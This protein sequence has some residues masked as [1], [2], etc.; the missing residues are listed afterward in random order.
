VS[1]DQARLSLIGGGSVLGVPVGSR[2]EARVPRSRVAVEAPPPDVQASTSDGEASTPAPTS[3]PVAPPTKPRPGERPTG[4]P[5]T[6]PQV[7]WEEDQPLLAEAQ[8]LQPEERRADWSGRVFIDGFV[9]DD[10]RADQ[11]FTFGRAGLDLFG[12]NPFGRGGEFQFSGEGAFQNSEFGGQPDEEDSQARLERLAYHWGGNRGDDLGFGVGR[13][14]QRAFPEF[15]LLDGGE[16]RWRLSEQ[17]SLSASIGLLPE[18]TDDLETGDDFQV[19][20]GFEWVSDESARNSVRLG[21]QK[22]WHMGT[23]DRDL[24]VLAVRFQPTQRTTFSGSAW[25]DLYGSEDDLKDSST[26]LTFATVNVDQR[27]GEASNLGLYYF[28]NRLPQTLRNEL[29]DLPPE[30]IEETRIERLGVRGS[31]PLTDDLRLHARLDS[32]SDEEDSGSGGEVR[33][34]WRDAFWDDGLLSAALFDN[35][36][37]TSAGTGVRL[38]ATKPFGAQ[39][40]SLS[41]NATRFEQEEFTGTQD[42]LLQH[43]VRL[44]WDFAWNSRWSGSV[45]G[46]ARFGDEQDATTLGLYLQRRF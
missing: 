2:G 38:R 37:A 29:G 19:A 8:A 26:E 27:L 14:L 17:H 32:W 41:W 1:R 25:V 39:S 21:F 10:R 16:V 6:A 43:L 20:L 11:S 3:G 5:W 9:T 42:E 22:T 45:Y 34:D 46:E 44:H 23:E 31:T 18:P 15:G 7:E 40:V 35:Q 24:G 4:L 36:G 28:Q 13:F 12:R 30:V 33:L